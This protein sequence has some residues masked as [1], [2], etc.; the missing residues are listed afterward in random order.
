LILFRF[1]KIIKIN[2]LNFLKK[3]NIKTTTV[4]RQAWVENIKPC[5]VLNKID[6]LITEWKMSPTEAY[7]H[8]Q[9]LLGENSFFFFFFLNF[10]YLN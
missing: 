1:Y 4:L 3:Q 8:L 9:K 6:R 5:L 2:G 10:V 7:H